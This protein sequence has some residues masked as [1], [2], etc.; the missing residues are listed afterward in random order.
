MTR[1]ILAGAAAGLMAAGC[2]AKTHEAK[3]APVSAPVAATARRD[4]PGGVVEEGVVT[5]AARVEAVDLK[6]RIVTLRGS[7]GKVV[8]VEVGDEVRNLP[9]VHKG[10]EVVATY[11]E[12]IAISVKK[13]G[14]AT[15]GIVSVLVCTDSPGGK[16]RAMAQAS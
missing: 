2:A 10:D 3:P 4:V 7:D 1:W 9:Q 5:V 8:D 15:P 11:Y 12:S 16:A 14:D 6:N 13:P